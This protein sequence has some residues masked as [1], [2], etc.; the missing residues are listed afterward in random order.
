MLGEGH[1][2]RRDLASADCWEA[3]SPPGHTPRAS[4][5]PAKSRPCRSGIWSSISSHPCRLSS[6]SPF[7]QSE[8]CESTSNLA[9]GFTRPR[10][11]APLLLVRPRLPEDAQPGDPTI[12]I[13]AR[14]VARPNQVLVAAQHGQTPLTFLSV[15]QARGKS[16]LHLLA[17]GWGSGPLLCGGKAVAGL[18][19]GSPR[20]R[21]LGWRP[22][23][24][25]PALGAGRS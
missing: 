11:S 12:G 3:T 22:G 25:V 14:S 16:M 4:G 2:S 20:G 10:G 19:W 17:V 9:Q 18:T 13:P 5:S 7:R 15:A 24:E 21:S 1:I 6:Q 8:S 23:L